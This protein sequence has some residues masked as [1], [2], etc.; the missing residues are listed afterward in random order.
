MADR[1]SSLPD[2]IL[3]HILSFLQTKHAVATSILS[4]RWNNLWLSVP[5]LDLGHIRVPDHNSFLRFINFVYLFFLYRDTALPIKT[6]HLNFD[7]SRHQ[8]PL[9]SHCP[10][11]TITNWINFVVQHRVEYIH[12]SVE[13]GTFPKT[14]LSILTCNTLVVLKLCFL[15]LGGRFSSVLLP[16]LKT[17]HFEHIWLHKLRDFMLFLTGCPIL[18]DIFTF[19]VRVNSVESLTYDEWK[20]VVLSNIIGADILRFGYFPLRIVHNVQSLS[21]D[22]HQVHGVDGFISFHNLTQL[23]FVCASPRYN[24]KFVLQLLKHCPKLQKFGINEVKLDGGLWWPNK[25][26]WVI[27]DVVP[28]C[29]SLHLTTCNLLSFSGLEGELKLAKYILKNAKVLET[30]TIR[31]ADQ[32]RIERVLSSC[33]R[34]SETSKITVYDVPCK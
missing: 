12:L 18:E 32:P 34:A 22:F 7:Y 29:L 10:M 26:N 1:I 15:S 11:D 21:S 5:S 19:D 23:Q 6:F 3:C 4:K 14:P 16:S 13:T 28:Q 2:S 30:M 33:T 25:E 24:W 8:T 31:N 17:L 9:F 27:P 20:S